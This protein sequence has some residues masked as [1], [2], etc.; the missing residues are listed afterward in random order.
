VCYL[1]HAG[2]IRPGDHVVHINTIHAGPA[3]FPRHTKQGRVSGRDMKSRQ[4]KYDDSGVPRALDLLRHASYC[5]IL[6]SL[7]TKALDLR[8]I[9]EQ[10]GIAR[11]TAWK[12]VRALESAGLVHIDDT[13][14]PLQISLAPSTK[15]RKVKGHIQFDITAADG[16]RIRYQPH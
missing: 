5:A 9:R 1:Q 8:S 7:R 11:S 2:L 3:R 16:S 10:T 14:G 13:Q 4:S 12:H 15:V 6:E